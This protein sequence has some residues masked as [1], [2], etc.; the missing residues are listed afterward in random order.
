MPPTDYKLSPSRKVK[1]APNWLTGVKA[2]ATKA[3]GPEHVE[4]RHRDKGPLGPIGTLTP[5][6]SKDTH[7]ARTKVRT[8]ENKLVKSGAGRS[9]DTPN[10]PTLTH[11]TEPQRHAIREA[12]HDKVMSLPQEDRRTFLKSL[13]DYQLVNTADRGTRR[14]I[15]KL[16][17]LDRTDVKYGP[18]GAPTERDL[19]TSAAVNTH[20][21]KAKKKVSIVPGV[22][23]PDVKVG[24]VSVVPSLNPLHGVNQALQLAAAPLFAEVGAVKAVNDGKSPLK[25]AVEN[26]KNR[27]YLYSDSGAFKGWNKT[28]KMIGGTA[29]DVLG[30]PANA[31]T[32]GAAPVAEHLVTQARRLRQ[33]GSDLFEAGHHAKAQ[34]YFDKATA[35]A[36]KAADAPAN[37]G[38]QVTLG[39]RNRAAGAISTSGKLTAKINKKLGGSALAGR[40]HDNKYAQ[41]VSR[42]LHAD[43]RPA[44]VDPAEWTTSGHITRK[45]RAATVNGQHRAAHEGQALNAVLGGNSHDAAIAALEA[46]TPWHTLTPSEHEAAQWYKGQ[47]E[48]MGKTELD[49]GLLDVMRPNYVTHVLT[50]DA[51]K[52]L[53]S[54]GRGGKAN[55]Y[56]IQRRGN[57]T[58]KATHDALLGERKFTTNLGHIHAER[59]AKHHTLIAHRDLGDETV[60]KLGKPYDPATIRGNDAIYTWGPTTGLKPIKS[61]KLYPTDEEIKAAKDGLLKGNEV[62]AGEQLVVLNRSIGDRAVDGVVPGARLRGRDILPTEEGHDAG[63]RFDRANAHLKAALTVYNLPSYQLRNF[64]GDA[65]NGRLAGTSVRD[66]KDGARL[67]NLRRGRTAHERKSLDA[68]EPDHMVDTGHGRERTAADLVKAME[69]RGVVGSGFVG[70]D[71]DRA[72]HAAESGRYVDERA[73]GRRASGRVAEKVRAATQLGE[74]TNRAGTFLSA[75][76]RGMS[77]DEAA[78]WSLHHHF[79][80]G[81]LTDFERKAKRLIPFWTFTARNTAL[82]AKHIFKRPSQYANYGLAQEEARKQS[83]LEPDWLT[84]QPGYLQRQLPL[85]V[86]VPRKVPLVGGKRVTLSPQWPLVDLNRPQSLLSG[87][88]PET[89]KEVTQM[90]HPAIKWAVEPAANYSTFFRDPLWQDASHPKARHYVNRPW[91][92]NQLDKIPGGHALNVTLAGGSEDAAK[93]GYITAKADYVLRA[94]PQGNTLGAVGTGASTRSQTSGEAILSQLTGLKINKLDKE[95][96]AK[97]KSNALYDKADVVAG[98]AA[99]AKKLG[100]P[101]QAKKLN[102][103]AYKLRSQASG[104]KA[105]QKQAGSQGSF[106][107]GG[108]SFKPGGG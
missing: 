34:R 57:L 21:L 46:D 97:N 49:R 108:G 84:R 70:H 5:V 88:L 44:G 65:W 76:R 20:H 106:K 3:A 63:L 13:E 16:Q 41:A 59:T 4:V 26:V 96:L 95:Q 86:N 30:D 55:P 47:H 73:I 60:A 82:Q 102:K 24:G 92:L 29:A 42:R 100:H 91:Y 75:V 38:I 53:K 69:D 87:D 28:A 66:V 23:I 80:Y 64:L 74:D 107:P 62:H 45:A 105:S 18:G 12:W 104:K 81:N 40:A 6:S 15:H 56:N 9:L 90:L 17:G 83:G 67:A 10:L 33:I 78:A 51:A 103:K 71:L 32:F 8:A 93:K 2:V 50:K 61:T 27:K 72:T 99:D 39:S 19:A 101:G 98:K 7:A 37:R 58:I 89:F 77:D 36:E 25:G 11:Y 1:A 43:T 79:D 14:Q 35:L 31:L 48:T 52:A 22:K 68:Y 85:G 94:L 54:G